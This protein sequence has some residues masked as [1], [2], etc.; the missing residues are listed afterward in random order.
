MDEQQVKKIE[1]VFLDEK[2]NKLERPPKFELCKDSKGRVMK[3]G[4]Y[5]IIVDNP[6]DYP[7]L[8]NRDIEKFVGALY[9]PRD[10]TIN[11]DFYSSG[12]NPHCVN[13]NFEPDDLEKATLSTLFMP[14]LTHPVRL[15]KQYKAIKHYR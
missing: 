13:L 8:E 15:F 1:A 2:G 7:G 11:V 6:P 4:D 5:V 3:L 12:E 10:G 9:F 14:V